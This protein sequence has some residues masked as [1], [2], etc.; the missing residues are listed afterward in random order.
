[1]ARHKIKVKNCNGGFYW[2]S[3][4]APKMNNKELDI[5][6]KWSKRFAKR[7]TSKKRRSYLKLET[8]D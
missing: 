2:L 4:P 7:Y 6:G 1:M 5:L 8:S 3:R